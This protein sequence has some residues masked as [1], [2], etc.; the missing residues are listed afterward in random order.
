MSLISVHNVMESLL[1]AL[2]NQQTGNLSNQVLILRLSSS[3]PTLFSALDGKLS[4]FGSFGWR[5][6]L[7]GLSG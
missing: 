2:R 7:Q 4:L 5:L 6:E 3:D 1:S